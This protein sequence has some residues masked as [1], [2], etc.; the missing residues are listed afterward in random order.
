[1]FA[2]PSE[3]S[4][5]I[6]EHFNRWYSL[7]SFYMSITVV[8]LP[9]SVVSCFVFSVIIY[10]MSAQPLDVARFLMFFVISLYT[11]LVA[12]SFGLM[13]GAAFNVVNGTFLGPALSV[14]M[15]MFAGFGI[16][17]RDLPPYL[18]W[19]SYVSYLRYGLEGYVG[20]IYGMNRTSLTCDPDKYCHYRIPRQFLKDVAMSA[21]MFWW[22]VLALTVIVLLLRTA[23]FLLLKWKL[24]AV[25]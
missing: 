15:M 5:L 25:R 3:M 14:P 19:G 21:D 1:M 17:L 2:V 16:T 8:D 9:I 12:Q 6:K 7:S 23:A 18:Y 20:A 24:N 13:I 4:I 10:F 11:V 22:D